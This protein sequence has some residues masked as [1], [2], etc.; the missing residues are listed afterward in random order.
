[1]LFGFGMFTVIIGAKGGFRAWGFVG[2]AVCVQAGFVIGLRAL[3]PGVVVDSTGFICSC[4]KSGNGA[5]LT[6]FGDLAR[7]YV[8]GQVTGKATRKTWVLVTHL[9]YACYAP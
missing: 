2:L 4:K 3:N 1:M 6:G 7:K 9:I 8:L 5:P